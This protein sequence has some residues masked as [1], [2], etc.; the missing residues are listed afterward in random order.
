[1]ENLLEP[2]LARRLAWSPPGEATVGDVATALRSGHA[3]PWQV[4]LAAPALADA[5]TAAVGADAPA[6]VV[7]ADVSADALA[8]ADAMAGTGAPTDAL[9]DAPAELGGAGAP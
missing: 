1:V 5:L 7:G 2:A 9:A 4:K 6:D 8:D 3:R